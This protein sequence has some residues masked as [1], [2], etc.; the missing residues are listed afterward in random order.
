M[1]PLHLKSAIYLKK[2]YRDLESGQRLKGEERSPG[3]VSE[4]LAGRG[5]EL[6][7]LVILQIISAGGSGFCWTA[8]SIHTEENLRERLCGRTAAVL[9]V[10]VVRL[11]AHGT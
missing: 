2:L 7:Q 6:P 4:L 5:G 11:S 9:G 3:E 1:S 8:D 10:L